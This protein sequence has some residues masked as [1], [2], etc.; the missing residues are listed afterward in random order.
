MQ[1]GLTEKKLSS[2]LPFLHG[3]NDFQNNYITPDIFSNSNF[4]GSVEKANEK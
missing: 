1:Y 3:G 4:F 2:S